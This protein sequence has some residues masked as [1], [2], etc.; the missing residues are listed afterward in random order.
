MRCLFDPHESFVFAELGR[1]VAA[2]E[3]LAVRSE[4]K[5]GDFGIS[6][7]ARTIELVPRCHIEKSNMTYVADS[8]CS[9]IVRESNREDSRLSSRR[10]EPHLS[11]GQVQQVHLASM[12]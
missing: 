6:S 1:F 8:Q 3:G 10:V 4:A 2:D 9:S 12:T 11:G 7:D 5:R